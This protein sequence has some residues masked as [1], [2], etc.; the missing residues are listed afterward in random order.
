MPE[1]D[2]KTL[3]NVIEIEMKTENIQLKIQLDDSTDSSNKRE[4]FITYL[5]S[6]DPSTFYGT[7]AAV[8]YTL[9]IRM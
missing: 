9:H 6:A 8:T 3:T 1:T 2:R 4:I 5:P 7:P